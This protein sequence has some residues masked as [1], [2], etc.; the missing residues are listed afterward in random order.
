[1]K[2][3]WRHLV[4]SFWRQPVASMSKASSHMYQWFKTPVG[5]RMLMQELELIDECRREYKGQVM[6][7]V[8][9]SGEPMLGNISAKRVKAVISSSLP[10]KTDSRLNSYSWLVSKMDTLPLEDGSVDF[11]VLHHSLEFAKNPHAALREAARVLAPQGH[12]VIVCFNPY[13]LFGVRKS[14]RV[15]PGAS[16]PWAHHSLS[17]GRISDWLELVNCQSLNV[18]WGFYS[19]PIQNERY[20]QYSAKIDQ[21][22]ARHGLP[23]GG[24]Y[25]IHACKKVDGWVGNIPIEERFPNSLIKFPVSVASKVKPVN[26]ASRVCADHDQ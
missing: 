9:A 24:F 4:N 13:S 3:G 10:K 16:I 7:Q 23:G 2:S 26:T 21:F 18:A 11:L 6:L 12:M 8:S 19:F 1:M 22:L 14:L 5:Q 17:R 20:L 15:I 25:V